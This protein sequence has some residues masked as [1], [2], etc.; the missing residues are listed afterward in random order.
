LNEPAAPRPARHLIRLFLERTGYSGICLP[1]LGIFIL[2][3]R[4][5]GRQ[6]SGIA[7]TSAS[8][9]RPTSRSARTVV[10]K[11]TCCRSRYDEASTLENRCTG[12]RTAGS[13]AR[14]PRSASV[15]NRALA[16]LSKSCAAGTSIFSGVI[17]YEQFTTR[18]HS[19][20]KLKSARHGLGGGGSLGRDRRYG[21]RGF[22]DREMD[23]R[24]EG[25][26]AHA[27]PPHFVVA[28]IGVV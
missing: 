4:L 11:K 27:D 10:M 8:S 15:T 28:A 26:D 16:C 5:T 25:A 1:P 12:N 22:P 24:T 23:E 6:I 7:P 13:E 14:G 18:S 17:G 20:K 21:P 2:A 9:N 3:D 19:I